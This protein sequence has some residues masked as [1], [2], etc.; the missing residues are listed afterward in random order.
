MPKYISVLLFLCSLLCLSWIGCTQPV[1]T[2]NG[3]FDAMTYNV[4]GLPSAITKDDTL[5]R[6][7]QIGP[8]LNPFAIVGLQETFV[9]EGRE[10]LIKASTHPH[11]HEY[12]ERIDESRAM[13][14]GLLFFSKYKIVTTKQQYYTTCF[15]TLDNASDCLASKGFH[16]IRI[17]LAEG[18]EIDVYNSHL[19]AGS[20]EEDKKVRATQV[21]EIKK[22]MKEW[23]DGKAILFLGD[24]NLKLTRDTDKTA[25]TDW[26]KDLNLTDGCEAVSCAKEGRI[27][28]IFFRSAEQ[29]QLTPKTWKIPEGF[30]DEKGTD[31]SD[32]EPIVVTFDWKEIVKT[33]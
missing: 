32:H 11:Q 24:T 9:D 7:K 8:K 22:A 10:D 6:L 14:P 17:E 21:S 16:M 4:H 15:G 29:L 2:R 25:I 31:L 19:E 33:M 20:G 26:L 28:R 30:V 13:G 18:L 12:S 5:G 1:E 3:S 23:S 27:D